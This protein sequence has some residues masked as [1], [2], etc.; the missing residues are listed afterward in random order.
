[1]SAIP[2]PLAGSRCDASPAAMSV[3]GLVLPITVAPRTPLP[4]R[5]D[6]L[7]PPL[8]HPPTSPLD[9]YL[10]TQLELE[11]AELQVALYRD[12]GLSGADILAHTRPHRSDF[13]Y[14]CG[15]QERYGMAVSA[16][17]VKAQMRRLVTN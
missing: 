9:L 1:M 6:R 11:L 2:P 4:L 10:L 7:E 15:Q 8:I 16:A 5:F 14:E 12:E 13:A 3:R 17:R